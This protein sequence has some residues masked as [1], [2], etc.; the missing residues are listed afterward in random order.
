V[1]STLS[2][3]E[4]IPV[5]AVALVEAAAEHSLLLRVTG[6]V[7]VKLRCVRH[8]PL[9]SRLGRRPYYDI[10]FWGLGKDH[11]QIEQFFVERG[12]VVDPRCRH[13][14]EWGIQRLIFKHPDT[15]VKIDVFMDELVMAHTIDFR[16][17]LELDRPTIS[18]T[19][20][21]LSKLQIH[22]ITDNDLMD[23]VVVLLECEDLDFDRVAGALG[24]DWGFW[25]DAV[26]NLGMLRDAMG[27]YDAIDASSRAIIEARLRQLEEQIEAE[28]KDRRWR[29]RAKVGTRKRWYELV[30]DVDR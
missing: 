8:S 23:L 6:S 11:R 5:E 4:R 2:L 1:E 14:R 30:G 10:D 7:A 17:R 9:L 22:E 25:Y 26:H 18:M 29:M 24:R 28:P 13:M 21:L 20:L 15:A 19:D 16:H 3:S 27:R 12:Y